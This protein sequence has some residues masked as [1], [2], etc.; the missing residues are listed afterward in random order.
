MYEKQCNELISKAIEKHNRIYP[1]AYNYAENTFMYNN[2]CFQIVGKCIFL[3]YN[4]NKKSTHI[5]KIS[6]DNENSH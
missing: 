6:I 4:D 2:H 5:I 1:I 3:W